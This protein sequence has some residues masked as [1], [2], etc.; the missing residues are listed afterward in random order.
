MNKKYILAS[1][2]NIANKLDEASLYKEASS[3]LLAILFRDANIYF[4]FID[5]CYFLFYLILSIICFI[6]SSGISFFFWK[7]DAARI[8]L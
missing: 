4:L 6:I 1:L 7:F 8:S 2:N 3:S 5:Y